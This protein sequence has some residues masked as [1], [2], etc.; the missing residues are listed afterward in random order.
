MS[1]LQ[2][3]A[4]IYGV[5]RHFNASGVQASRQWIKISIAASREILLAT[6][7]H[8]SSEAIVLEDLGG[9]NFRSGVAGSAL[10]VI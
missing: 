8:C 10:P 2:L 9:A 4:H 6:T 3:D 7:F 5:A 1:L